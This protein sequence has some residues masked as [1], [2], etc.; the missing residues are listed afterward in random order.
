MG[1]VW[2]RFVLKSGI[3]DHQ[4]I[5]A[6]DPPLDGLCY[7][8]CEVWH[9]PLNSVCSP[10]LSLNS[11]SITGCNHGPVPYSMEYL[12]RRSAVISLILVCWMDGN[13]PLY[14]Q[15]SAWSTVD[16]ALQTKPKDMCCVLQPS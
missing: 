10:S 12:L 13:P 11:S 3:P 7:D 4:R 1:I 14:S 9:L 5:H 8:Y 6:A 16:C 15:L 2:C